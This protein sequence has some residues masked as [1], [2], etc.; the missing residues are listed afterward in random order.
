M[1]FTLNF[2]Q[3]NQSMERMNQFLQ[4]MA[5]QGMIGQRSQRETLLQDVLQRGRQTAEFSQAKEMEATR[6]AATRRQAFVEAGLKIAQT[7]PGQRLMSLVG[8]GDIPDI[9]PTWK[10]ASDQ[11]KTQLSGILG[12]LADAMAGIHAGRLPATAVT[13]ILNAGTPEDMLKAAQIAGENQRAFLT[14]GTEAAR[15]K[16]ETGKTSQTQENLISGRWITDIEQAESYLTRQGVKDPGQAWSDTI[17]AALATQG[18]FPDPM[19]PE[20]RGYAYQELEKIRHQIINGTNPDPGQQKFLGIVYNTSAWGIPPAT[21]AGKAGTP[22]PTPAAPAPGAAPAGTPSPATGL[23]PANQMQGNAVLRQTL[24][25][26]Y[27]EKF[28]NRVY[29]QYYDETKPMDPTL[30]TSLY[31]QAV[32]A[33]TDFVNQLEKK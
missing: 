15:I 33:A 17:R 8:I 4:M 29:P 25:D 3:T 9:P 22:G 7:G 2:N 5:L 27:T 12:P 11:A 19:S 30:K 1:P 26:Q 10:T 18:S 31:N 20:N 28:L 6:A 23:T 13:D 24:I 21:P 32:Q 14:A 16:M